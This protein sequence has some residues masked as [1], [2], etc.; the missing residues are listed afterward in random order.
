MRGIFFGCC[1][2]AGETVPSKTL[3]SSQKRMD[4]VSGII[5]DV[6]TGN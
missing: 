2:C 3:V 4:V 1:V 6:F 5:T